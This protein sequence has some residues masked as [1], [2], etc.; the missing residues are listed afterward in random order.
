MFSTEHSLRFTEQKLKYTQRSTSKDFINRKGFKQCNRIFLLLSQRQWKKV[1]FFPIHHTINSQKTKIV[2]VWQNC[3]S[4]R[5]WR[6]APMNGTVHM[7][8][9]EKRN[10][11]TA[12]SASKRGALSLLKPFI[13]KQWNKPL[14]ETKRMIPTLSK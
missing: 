8:Q 13:L 5:S 6:W 10:R 7:G 3:W 2:W 4:R 14:N 12:R 1:F 11:L 9:E